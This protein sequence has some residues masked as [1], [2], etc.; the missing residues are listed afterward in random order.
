MNTESEY[1]LDVDGENEPFHAR[2]DEEMARAVENM[3]DP[4]A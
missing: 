1:T 2:N 4:C 3:L